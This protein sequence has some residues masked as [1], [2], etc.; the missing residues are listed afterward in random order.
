M[1]PPPVA[2]LSP[3]ETKPKAWGR[4][5]GAGQESC[6]CFA[7]GQGRRS[8]RTQWRLE[9]LTDGWRY[10]ICQ[11]GGRA[12]FGEPKCAEQPSVKPLGLPAWQR[13]SC[14]GHLS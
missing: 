10:G 3:S 6:G 1:T 13:S 2:A 11:D 9:W 5:A 8:C 14:P 12:G 7:D 4:A